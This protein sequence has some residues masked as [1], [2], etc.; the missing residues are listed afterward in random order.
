MEPWLKGYL[1]AINLS[2]KTKY[3]EKIIM[4]LC[5]RL[6]ILNLLKFFMNHNIMN[7]ERFSVYKKDKI[8]YEFMK[9]NQRSIWSRDCVRIWVSLAVEWEISSLD[10]W[11]FCSC[12]QVYKPFLLKITYF[13]KSRRMDCKEGILLRPSLR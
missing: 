4:A 5:S 1:A 9:S 13:R 10:L 8:I 6:S 2:L 12:W 7:Y 11:F 3:Y